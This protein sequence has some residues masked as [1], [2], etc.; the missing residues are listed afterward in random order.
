MLYLITD[1]I[2]EVFGPLVEACA[3]PLGPE[4]ELPDRIFFEAV[5]YRARTVRRVRPAVGDRGPRRRVQPPPTLD[6]P[7]PAQ[8]AFLPHGRAAR[9]RGAAAADDRLDDCPRT[10]A[11]GRGAE[12]KG[13]AARQAIGRSRGG[14]TTKVIAV[15]RDEDGVVAVGVAE[16]QR[17]DAGLVA[18]VLAEAKGVVGRVAGVL[19]DKGFDADAVRG[20]ILEGLKALPVI[21]NRVNRKEPW[22]WD[23]EM[24]E[25]YKERDR[26][27][28]LLGKA[29]QFRG[30]ATRYD[31]LKEVYLG[32]VRLIFGFIHVRRRAKTVNRP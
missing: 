15:A 24:R 8:E 3:S 20:F 19:A 21:P 29:E 26:V 7:R 16:G 5:L 11:L 14:P 1:A 13:G 17:H 9:V 30:L 32:L 12:V 10:S 2:W 27:E 18:P 31:K 4:P 23:D 22:P 6:Q 25:A 28:R